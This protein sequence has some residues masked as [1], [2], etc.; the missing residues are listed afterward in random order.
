MRAVLLDCKSR[1]EAAGIRPAAYRGGHY[2]YHPFMNR[3]LVENGVYVDCSCAPGMNEPGREAVWTHAAAS[4]DYLPENPRAPAGGQPRSA[5]FEIPIGSDGEGAAYRNL[6]HVEQSELDNLLRIWDV[7]RSRARQLGRPQ[8]VHAL[9]HTGSVARP[10]WLDRYRRFL[11]L[12]PRRGGAFV[13]ALEA[14]ALFD[15]GRT[16]AAA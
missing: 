2:A 3:L 4:A 1:L 11:D 12:V 10:E 15:A 14:K 9:F 7:L 5:V 6:L 8:I 13:N 16:E